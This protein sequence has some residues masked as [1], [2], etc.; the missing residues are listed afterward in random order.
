ML[1]TEPARVGELKPGLNLN[2]AMLFLIFRF[3]YDGKR[4]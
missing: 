3:K 2:G 1:K 4:N